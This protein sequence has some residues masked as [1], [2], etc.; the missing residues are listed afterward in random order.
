[1]SKSEKTQR[2]TA[3]AQR[4][5]A[6]RAR[7]RAELEKMKAQITLELLA[8]PF[9][10]PFGLS[11]AIFRVSENAGK[12]RKVHSL[13][14]RA[15][16]R[17]EHW[18]TLR[19]EVKAAV[20]EKIGNSYQNMGLHEDAEPCLQDALK[21]LK[22]CAQCDP[23][24]LAE[25][26]RSLARFHHDRGRL[27]R[28]DYELSQEW[29]AAALEIQ[30]QNLNKNAKAVG[31]T[32]FGMAWLKVELE[33]HVA[34]RRL[35]NE[36]IALQKEYRGQFSDNDQ[37]AVRAHISLA[38]VAAEEKLAAGQDPGILTA[39]GLFGYTNA[40]LA[41]DGDPAWQE[42]FKKFSDGAVSAVRNGKLP[43]PRFDPHIQETLLECDSI[44]KGKDP[45]HFYR[46]LPHLVLAKAL[47]QAEKLVD[48]DREY[49]K[50]LE[51]VEK[52]VGPHHTLM[53]TVVKL[54]AT[55]LRKQGKTDDALRRFADVITAMKN[56]FGDNHFYVANARM[57]FALFLKEIR[58]Y[59]RVEEEC[60]NALS[61]YD[62]LGWQGHSR[63]KKCS[64][65]L[66]EAR[67]AQIK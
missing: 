47:D 11:G 18:T 66:T 16:E 37:L 34:A 13:L 4:D 32:K 56:R 28:R 26:Y 42:A 27:D 1:L 22:G 38:L 59:P 45:E 24:D 43:M 36:I 39:V 67:K 51:I 60:R 6:D 17:L 46:A 10:E 40:L 31:E 9:D 29:Y 53:P 58:D 52:T 33:E 25:C 3:E 61:I 49:R 44:I 2:A 14:K 57:T 21:L 20:L 15:R 48:A 55:V 35:F 8:D 63:Y 7:D 54:Y 23:L 41:L 12:N 30:S 64:D 50:C 65:L 19:P 5:E 62:G